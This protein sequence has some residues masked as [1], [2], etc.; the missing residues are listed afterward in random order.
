MIT[1]I[2]VTMAMTTVYVTV[3]RYKFMKTWVNWE[4]M[5]QKI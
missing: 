2:T 5:S 4:Y 1:I 3:L